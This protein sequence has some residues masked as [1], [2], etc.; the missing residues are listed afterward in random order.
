[1]QYGIAYEP[2][3]LPDEII[4]DLLLIKCRE[5]SKDEYS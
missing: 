1:M 3:Y 4:A 5:F 2:E